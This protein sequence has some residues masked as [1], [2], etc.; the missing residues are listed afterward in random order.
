V[1]ANKGR[2]KLG[3]NAAGAGY[4]HVSGPEKCANDVMMAG[5]FVTLPDRVWEELARHT[6]PRFDHPFNAC[7]PTVINGA[8]AVKHIGKGRRR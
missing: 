1:G 6:D 8:T 3:P 5:E 2:A 7:R 4:Q